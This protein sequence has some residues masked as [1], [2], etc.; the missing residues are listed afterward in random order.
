VPVRDLLTVGASL[1][2]VMELVEGGSVR[3]LLRARGTLPP[4][5]A[6]TIMAS[7]AEALAHPHSLGVVH[8]DL[9]PGNILL[10]APSAVDPQVRLT[11]FGIARVLGTPAL[12][13]TGAL[14]GTPNYLAPEVVNGARPTPAA[15]VYAFGVV[16]Y[17]L[18][19]GRSPY[20]GHTP[21]TALRRHVSHRPERFPGIPD[22]L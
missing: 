13:T 2:L 20:G 4:A 14:I 5:E 18:L 16:L 22:A 11:D 15:D 7:V 1:G 9:K 8:R 19:V 12:T 3:D 17:E 21:R 10:G 6:A